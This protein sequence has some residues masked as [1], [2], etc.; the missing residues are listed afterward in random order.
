MGLLGPAQRGPGAVR[1]RQGCL[2]SLGP[3]TST[4]ITQRK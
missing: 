4:A 2:C 1:A 3:A